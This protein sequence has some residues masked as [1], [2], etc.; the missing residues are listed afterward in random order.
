MAHWSDQVNTTYIANV[1]NRYMIENPF[2]VFNIFSSHHVANLLAISQPTMKSD[3]L[4]IGTTS[5]YKRVGASES[6]G[7]DYTVGKQGLS[8][9]TDLP[10]R[11]HQR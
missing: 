9:R 3:W 11:H 7:D 6:V 4:C 2:K 8:L 10:Q 5:L 1:A